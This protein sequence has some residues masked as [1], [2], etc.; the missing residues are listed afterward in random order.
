M[1]VIDDPIVEELR[2]HRKAFA[3]AHGN[4][5]MQIVEAW[6]LREKAAGVPRIRF[7]ARRA[8]IAV[9]ASSEADNLL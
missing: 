8:G 2:T 6:R 7:A 9:A 4:D 1:I 3:E 5:L